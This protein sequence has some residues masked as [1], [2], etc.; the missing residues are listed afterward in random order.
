VRTLGQQPVSRAE[1]ARWIALVRA[2]WT[3]EP[4]TTAS[5][6]WRLTFG[7]ADRGAPIVLAGRG[8]KMLRLAGQIADGAIVTS[9][10]RADARLRA[11]LDCVQAGRAAAASPQGRP[12]RTYLSIPAAVDADRR[13]AIAA[14][15]PQVAVSLL[16]PHWTLSGVA[17]Q[18]QQ[19]LRASYDYYQHMSR[20]PRYAEVIPD[21]IVPEFALAGTPDE[22]VQQLRGLVTQGFHE[23]T[24]CPY[25]IDGGTR[26][27]MI[28][29]LAREVLDRL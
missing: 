16:M 18:A 28:G 24:L 12:F 20:Q 10:G 11:M 2:L 15:R 17:Q 26:A 19:Q 21:E 22:C 4:V 1:L 27:D 9:S 29:A 13:K 7:A 14:A 23:I 6:A 5:G 25:A 3:G 8:P